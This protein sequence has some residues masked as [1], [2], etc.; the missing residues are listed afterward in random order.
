MLF[1]GKPLKAI[2]RA[3]LQRLIDNAQPEDKSLEYKETAYTKEKRDDFLADASAFANTT[4]GLL[5]LG[6]K[7]DKGLPIALSGIPNATIDDT[8]LRIQCWM[9]DCLDP[10]LDGVERTDV[11]LGNGHRVLIFGIPKSWSRPHMVKT[12]GR[13]YVRT[14]SGNEPCDCGQVRSLVLQADEIS[15]RIRA[16]RAERIAVLLANEGP[17]RLVTSQNFSPQ[18]PAQEPPL[19]AIH[20]VPL[21]GFGSGRQIDL[22]ACSSMRIEPMAWSG[23]NC[24]R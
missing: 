21:G 16:W 22:A 4:D 18:E 9:R 17:E 11:D 19:V 13:F 7:S 23:G 5:L 15:K 14:N 3:D 24:N 6:V 12:T 8:C 20:V 1:F 10:R 2:D